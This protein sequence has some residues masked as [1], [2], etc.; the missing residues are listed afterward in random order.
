MYK[1]EKSGTPFLEVRSTKQKLSSIS[2]SARGR[3]MVETAAR[4]TFVSAASPAVLHVAVK[5]F[6]QS[7]NPE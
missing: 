6:K 7:T 2:T 1:K 5:I 4:C 3:S